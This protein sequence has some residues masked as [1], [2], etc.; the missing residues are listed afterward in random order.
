VITIIRPPVVGRLVSADAS[1]VGFFPESH[2]ICLFQ[3]K[4]ARDG[5]HS[6]T[7]GLTVKRKQNAQLQEQAIP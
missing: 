1:F 6:T 7:G 4:E 2:H 5:S 3:W